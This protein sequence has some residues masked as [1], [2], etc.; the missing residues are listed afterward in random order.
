MEYFARDPNV[1]S[2]WAT[3]YRTGERIPMELL[4]KGLHNKRSF[5]GVE[6]QNQILFSAAD[7][8]RF[9]YLYSFFLLFYLIYS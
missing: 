7:Q 8:V 2:K 5:I 3:H 9:F 1:I 4:L 6:Y